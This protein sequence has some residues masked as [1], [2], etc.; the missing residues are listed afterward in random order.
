MLERL[1]ILISILMLSGCATVGKPIEQDKL[2][3][4]K[5]GQTTKQEVINLLGKPYMITLGSD[6]KEIMTYQYVKSQ[7][8]AS[9]MVPIV[10]LFVGG[11][12]TKQQ[13]FQVLIDK[14]GKVEKYVF[15]DSDTPIN[16]GLLNTSSK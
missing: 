7:I 5:E 2:A 16:S 14:D 3:S 4:I 11:A 6:G 8:R 1:V 12:D 10:G 15:T 9:T 13:I